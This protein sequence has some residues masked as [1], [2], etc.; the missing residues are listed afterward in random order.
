MLAAVAAGTT[1]ITHLA[2]GGDVRSTLGCLS[3]LGADV[4]RLGEGHIRVR[5]L[6]APGFR[7]P[8]AAL[9]AGN[10]GTTMRLLAGLLAGFP[11][12]IRLEGDP[13]LSRRPMRRVIEPLTAMGARI[14]SEDSPAPARGGRRGAHRHPLGVARRRAPRSSAILLAP[15]PP[16]RRG[17]P[18]VVEPPGDP[19]PHGAGAALLRGRLQ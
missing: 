15:A 7:T 1:E 19:R 13:S 8:D 12:H 17:T 14:G 2:P 6:G 9:D 4:A 11:L 5:G 3:A 16:P 10:S 18:S